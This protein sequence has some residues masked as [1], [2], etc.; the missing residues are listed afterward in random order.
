VIKIEPLTGDD[1]RQ[2]RPLHTGQAGSGSLF[3]VV[4]GG[5]RSLAIDL[6]HPAGQALTRR[7]ARGADVLI[8]N[9]SAGVM[10]R[11]GLGHQR[12]RAHNPRLVYCTISAFGE[13]GPLAHA[14]GYDPMLQA[15]SGM[16]QIPAADGP[17]SARTPAKCCWNWAAR[18]RK[19]IN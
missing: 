16:M 10:E 14:R 15:F 9:F 11:L 17:A 8:Q 7:L 6:K 5:K 4:N 12:L 19:S 18:R 2:W 3:L 13:T 1:A